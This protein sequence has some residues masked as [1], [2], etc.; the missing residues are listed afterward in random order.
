MKKIYIALFA[1][2]VTGFAN[3]QTKITLD[4]ISQHIGDSVTFCGLVA[5]MRYFENTKNQPTFLN[6]GDKYPNQK[7]TIVIWGNLR[8]A[9]KEK[10]ETLLNKQVCVTGKIILYKEKPEIIIYHPEQITTE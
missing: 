7:V 3:A 5:D 8:G 2:M 10:P 4:D 6:I 1:L 9:F